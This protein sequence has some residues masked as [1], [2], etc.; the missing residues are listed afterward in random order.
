M[1]Q[2]LHSAFSRIVNYISYA[3][4]LYRYEDEEFIDKFF[5]T[6]ELLISS[7]DQ[8]SQYDDNQLGDKSEGISINSGRTDDGGV[9]VT[10]T[11]VGHNSYCFCTSTI[12][13]KRLYPVFKR[14]SVFRIKEPLNFML[15]IEKSISRVNEV[16]YGN[17]IYKP[18]KTLKKN[19]PNINFEEMKLQDG[20]GN[21]S[22]DKMMQKTAQ[23]GFPEQFFLKKNE[24][25]RTK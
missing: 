25:S 15:E 4:Y 2:K 13:S 12:L 7:F 3:P 1:E 17:C 8:Y 18:E 16:L 23:L 14:N 21:I 11:K 19:I 10:V 9:L 20:S 22:M 6:G 5:D 24:V